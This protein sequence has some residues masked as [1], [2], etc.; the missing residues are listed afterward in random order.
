MIK[1]TL[2]S[3]EEF[4][5]LSDDFLDFL[6]ISLFELA[7]N[8]LKKAEALFEATKIAL[9]ELDI[10]LPEENTDLNTSFESI[11]EIFQSEKEELASAQLF[12]TE[13]D[14]PNTIIKVKEVFRLNDIVREQLE[15]LS[16]LAFKH[17]CYKKIRSG[18]RISR[19]KACRKKS[20][21]QVFL[22]IHIQF[23]KENLWIVYGELQIENIIILIYGKEFIKQIKIK[24]KIQI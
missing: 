7:K 18:R 23:K 10:T 22:G 11:Q 13:K 6:D 19:N 15:N 3:Y 17:C 21:K 4:K 2:F 9:E 24:S 5:N 16:V 8:Q 14:F 20:K 12:F 1:Q